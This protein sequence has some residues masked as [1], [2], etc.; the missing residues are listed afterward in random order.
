[1][2]ALPP[3][4]RLKNAAEFRA[5]MKQPVVRS[6]RFFRVLA[7]RSPRANSRLGLAVSRRVDKRAVARNSIKRQVR[8]AFR[9][10]VQSAEPVALDLVVIAR[11][12]ARGATKAELRQAAGRLMD[13]V[14]CSGQCHAPTTVG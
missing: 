4:R 10:Q 9:R 2:S 3:D 14:Y 8:E 13:A 7:A 1:M 12:A 11:S 6:N 5:V